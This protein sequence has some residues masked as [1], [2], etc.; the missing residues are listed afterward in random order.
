[1]SCPAAQCSTSIPHS[2]TFPSCSSAA[3]KRRKKAADRTAKKAIRK[4][5][6]VS[7]VPPVASNPALR[8]KLRQMR[9]VQRNLVYVVGLPLDIAKETVS[10]VH[11][12]VTGVAWHLQRCPQRRL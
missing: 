6:P 4:P 2:F 5:V 12:R 11:V 10:A 7:A 1:M 9:V 3:E 8:D